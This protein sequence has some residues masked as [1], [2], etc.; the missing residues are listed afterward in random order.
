MTQQVTQDGLP[1]SPRRRTIWPNLVWLIPVAALLVVIY[2]GVQAFLR[3]GELVTVTFEHAAGAR[4]SDTKVVYH[5]V[6]A[7]QLVKISPNK[8][9]RRLD[10]QLRLVPE[11]KAGLTENARFWLIGASPNL[12]D[13]SSLKAV[14]SGVEIGYAPGEGGTPQ[15]SFEGLEE[16]PLIL[17]GD[18]G[19]RYRLT[20]RKLNSVRAGSVVLYHGQTIGKVSEVQF[21]DKS[22]FTVE[23]FVYQPFDKLITAGSRFWKISPLRL[24]FAGGGITANLAPSSSLLA[25]G[26]DVDLPTA[27]AG[28]PKV[29]PGTQFILYESHNAAR[30]GL[31]G[32]TVRYEFTF[33]GTAGA[34]EQDTAVTLLGFQIGEVESAHLEF[35]ERSGEPYTIATAAIYPQ[36]LHIGD[37]SHP[38]DEALRS[39]TDAKLRQLV[40][41]GYRARLQQTPALFG[42]ESIAL[43]KIKGAPRADLSQDGL[44]PRFPSAVASGGFDELGTQATQLLATLNGIPFDEIG[45]NLKVITARLKQVLASPKMDE[46]IAH[47]DSTLGSIDKILGEAEPQIVPLLAK[48]N[49]TATQLSSTAHEAHRL[50]SSEGGSQDASLNEAIQQ[51]T[52]AARSI[53][54]LTDY[55]SR[56]PEALIRGKGSSP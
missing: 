37:E 31:S 23:I 5:G 46:S 3:R 32:P 15:S 14:V 51:L 13:L 10:F 18:K 19:V 1:S 26:I 7:G 41:A 38:S 49:D 56:H 6:E 8:D 47:L 22:A 25:G 21:D 12:A 52:E 28:G 20:A 55:L 40:R 45:G 29:G 33:S 2:L 16:A 11:A 53:R 27:A 42:D 36:Q 34:L 43:V 9:G 39:L 48:L 17:P 44:S 50:L 54:T 35:D 24:S 4:P 30:Q